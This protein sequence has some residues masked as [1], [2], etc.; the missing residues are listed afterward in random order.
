MI[1]TCRPTVNKSGNILAMV[2]A[3][4]YTWLALK[5]ALTVLEKTLDGVPIPGLKGAIGGF[6]EIAKTVEA[7]I[8]NSEDILDLQ[9]H[10]MKLTRIFQRWSGACELP[11]E[12]KPRIATFVE[13]VHILPSHT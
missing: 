3:L 11:A 6:L 10:I 2:N 7:S 8:Q 5:L 4:E 13:W 9:E 1:C 12:L